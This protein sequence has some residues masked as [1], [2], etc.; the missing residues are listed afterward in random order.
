LQEIVAGWL[1]LEV[2][3][4]THLCDSLH[5]YE[6][7]IETMRV[8]PDKQTY[9]NE[10]SCHSLALSKDKFDKVLATLAHTL[11]RLSATDL[12]QQEF[13]DLRQAA[14]IPESYK[15]YIAVL[16]AESARRRGWVLSSDGQ[17]LLGCSDPD[18]QLVWDRW[19]QRVSATQ[20]LI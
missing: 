19:M 11:R 10:K 7:D 4:Y 12:D 2:G 15:N 20:V 9:S 3:R 17:L 1:E 14:N 18:L 13:D 6:A 8:Q 5:L 16:A